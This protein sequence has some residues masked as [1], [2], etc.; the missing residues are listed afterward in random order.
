MTVN[1][2]AAT[3][4]ALEAVTAEA[5]VQAAVTT[6]AVRDKAAMD[7]EDRTPREMLVLGVRAVTIVRVRIE[8]RAAAIIRIRIF[9][10]T[11]EAPRDVLE[12]GAENLPEVWIL[13]AP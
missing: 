3:I 8:M 13:S 9:L 4:E 10:V 6:G 5:R 1:P 12:T 2:E 7:R 11:A